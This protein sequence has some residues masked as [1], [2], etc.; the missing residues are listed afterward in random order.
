LEGISLVHEP[1]SLSSIDVNDV[2]P[3]LDVVKK[4]VGLIDGLL[5]ALC[6][7][8]MTFDHKPNHGISKDMD[9]AKTPITLQ[10]KVLT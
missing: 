5:L 1:F 3:I 7:G 4:G 6:G 2:E 8:K 9:E 10:N